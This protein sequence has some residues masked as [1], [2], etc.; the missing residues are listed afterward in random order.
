MLWKHEGEVG[1]D[2]LRVEDKVQVGRHVMLLHDA[3]AQRRA[4]GPGR[5]LTNIR[6][7]ETIDLTTDNETNKQQKTEVKKWFKIKTSF[8]VDNELTR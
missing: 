6:L 8:N 5:N 3:G 4:R 7:I 2:N 1:H